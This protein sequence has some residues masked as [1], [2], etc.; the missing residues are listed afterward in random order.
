M[1]KP[2]IKSLAALFLAITL[3]PCVSA[4]VSVTTSR[5]NNLRNGLTQQETVLTRSNVNMG[6]FGK[7]CSA[8]LDGQVYAQPLIVSNV[9][10]NG[11][12][13][14][15]VAYVVTMNDSV[16]AFD[17][18]SAGPTCNQ[19]LFSNLLPAGEQPIA[20]ANFG[21]GQ[22]WAMS[23]VIGILSTP[24]INA[25]SKTIYLVTQSQVGSQPTGYFHRIHALDISSFNEKFNGPAA[26]AGSYQGST[27]NS[28]NH[29]QRPGLLLLAGG[30]NRVYVGL[31]LMDGVKGRPSGWIFGFNP[32]NLSAPPL[33]FATAPTGTNAG[34]GIWEAGSGLAS[35]VDSS[36][37]TYIYV[38][39]GDG[40]LTAPTGGLDYGDS[41]IKVKTDLSGV[42]AYF[43][44]FTQACMRS[45]DLDFGS[46]GVMIF[47]PN[48]VP[49][50][51]YA[52]ITG[53]K[54]GTLYIVDLDNPGGYHGNADCTGTN[55]NIQTATGFL[56]F[57]NPTAYWNHNIYFSSFGQTPQTNLQMYGIGGTCSPGPLCSTATAS[58]A[59]LF[60]AGANPSVS[61]NG[62]NASTALV[63][64]IGGPGVASGGAPAKLY[65][66]DA[67]NLNELYDSG[68]CGT[69]DVPGPMVKF[70]VPTVANG[71]V[72]IG[73]QTDFDIYGELSSSRSCQ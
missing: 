25:A 61:V 62:T 24:V 54:E 50:H 73:T 26:L 33:A 66:F 8:T 16:Y 12:L 19:L 5:Y 42:A 65:A 10:I 37:T 11:T 55:A 29:L 72:F 49:G 22:C 38:A 64:V 53:S 20:C 47:P 35:G 59:V 14:S 40:N 44:P 52:E 30:V 2:E 15:A 41:L 3:V 39:T 34:A 63:W 36:G 70:S 6:Q 58:S 32:A 9:T 13:Y 60:P 1:V 7:I 48:T 71:R 17:A 46:G 57:H 28:A 43:S 69:Q 56:H 51:P 68:Q 4:Q 23:P 45:G 67:S 27:F 21:G 31:S 18:N